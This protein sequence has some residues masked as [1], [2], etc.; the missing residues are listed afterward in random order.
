MEG[1][2]RREIG[3]TKKYKDEEEGDWSRMDVRNR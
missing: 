1:G 3:K 2:D